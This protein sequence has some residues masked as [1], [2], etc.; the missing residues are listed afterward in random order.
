[1][2]VG[3]FTALLWFLLVSCGFA[4]DWAKAMFDH[5]FHDFGVVARG[6][7]VEHRFTLKNIYLED[8]QISSTRSTCGC[9]SVQIT[10]QYLKTYD[11]AEIVAVLDTKKFLGHKEATI[12]VTF[13]Q[14]YQA[15][16]QLRVTSF[17]RGD[18][19]CEPGAVHFGTVVQGSRAPVQVLVTYA[20]RDDWKITDI[21]SNNPYLA[22]T[23]REVS[24][25]QG[26]VTYDLGIILTEKAPVGYIKDFVLVATNDLSPQTARLTLPV[27][28]N[29]IPPPTAVTAGPSPLL[30][31][32]VD[33][34]Q[35]ATRNLVVRGKTPFRILE[36][37]G[38][39]SRFRF[40]HPTEAKTV[41]L[42]P[43]TLTAGVTP[44][45]ITG[46]IRI[47]T[48]VPGNEWLEVVVD[49]RVTAAPSGPAAPK[50]TST[51]P[52]TSSD[53]KTSAPPKTSPVVPVNPS[54]RS[55]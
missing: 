8:V 9:T 42:V 27:D 1:M 14:P 25:F 52:S 38:P 21:Q 26:K 24:R 3:L 36:I 32:A 20:G 46:K 22:A 15:E 33:A 55:F 34:G 29:V 49:G 53:S 44:G 13:S 47:R 5:T 10:K 35:T 31:G 18:V 23:I 28:G 30:F 7:N 6:S 40:Q 45:L 2:R 48:D 17:I 16:V 37:T 12:T 41:H 4:Q 11:T 50:S 19:V 54:K 51:T 39:D 43:A